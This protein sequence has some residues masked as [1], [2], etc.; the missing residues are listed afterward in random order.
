MMANTA[1]WLLTIRTH[2]DSWC[3]MVFLMNGCKVFPVIT[4]VNNGDIPWSIKKNKDNDNS[5]G[6]S[7][8]I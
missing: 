7:P 4:R 1:S 3:L 2:G 6:Y 8:V 5:W